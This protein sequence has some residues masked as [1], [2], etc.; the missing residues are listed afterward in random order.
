V[1]SVHFLPYAAEKNRHIPLRR[2][3]PLT[4]CSTA[5]ALSQD[6]LEKH[7]RSYLVS[8]W[9]SQM[10]TPYTAPSIDEYLRK[11]LMPVEGAIP[12]VQGI[13]MYGNSIPA[14]T[15]GGD[16]FEY[17]NFQQRYDIDAR[18]QRALKRSKEYLE[19]LPTGAAPRNSVDDHVEWLKS[20]P[21]YKPEMETEY[22]AARSSE[23]VRVAEDLRELYST[24]GVLVVDAQGHGI[25][26]A[27]IASTVH[28]TF[29]ALMLSE[30]DHRGK[31]T[32]ELFER[33]NLRLA[34]SV[35]ARNALGR[36]EKESAQEIATMLYGEV[37]PYGHFRFV[38][39]GH[40]P[41]LVFSAEYRKFMDIGKSGMVQF[42]PLGVQIAE[43]DPDRNRYFSLEPRQRRANS[44]DVAELTLMSP[45]DILF[46]Y[47]DGVYDG[48]DKEER[49]QL[50]NVMRDH[51][52][53]SVKDICNA[54]LEY[55]VK[56]DDHLREISEQDRID[57]KTVFIIKRN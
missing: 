35:T 6:E 22:R 43:D 33:I 39:F 41:P 17:I 18:I 38:N 29:H 44:S 21:G 53:L 46:L 56:K 30:L 12:Y 32:A 57:D 28:D 5:S 8:V 16:L 40:P 42:L 25:I 15:V 37:R 2:V 10:A 31:T 4:E 20:R 7:H 19:L 47:T 49:Q 54:L 3:S 45:G 52:V 36:S 50:E 51:H 11:R 1:I 48:S 9:S 26:S 34:L 14:G 27:K 13:E 24:A 23:Q 55:A